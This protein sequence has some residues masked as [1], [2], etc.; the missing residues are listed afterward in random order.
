MNMKS[1][2]ISRLKRA[3]TFKPKVGA[4]LI[5]CL[6]FTF[7]SGC[8][9][10][11]KLQGASLGVGD[12]LPAFSV[13]LADGTVIGTTGGGISLKGKKGL[14][15]FFNTECP[16]CRQELPE[17]QKVWE[18]YRENPE[19]V[20]VAIAREE[21]EEEI[22]NYWEAN[23]LTI[24]FSP[25]VNREVYSLFAQSVIPRIYLFDPDLSIV[26]TSGDEDMPDSELLI[27]EIEKI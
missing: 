15:M 11:E 2:V 22:M 21:G 6:L 13:T 18:K 23:G 10:D 27:S 8:I 26:F 5:S 24:P 9:N 7:L 19:V 17:V 16:D 12:K 4:V 3:L 1:F 14:I 20:V 25:Q